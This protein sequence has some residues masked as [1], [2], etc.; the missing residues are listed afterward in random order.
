MG[1]PLADAGAEI[2]DNAAYITRHYPQSEVWT[3]ASPFGDKGWSGP[4]RTRVFI[5]RGVGAG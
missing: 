1:E 3:M 5:N 2:E 4:A